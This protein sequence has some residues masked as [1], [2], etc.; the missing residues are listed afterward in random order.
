M[1]YFLYMYMCLKHL[2]YVP[3]PDT[4]VLQP[5]SQSHDP[6]V[7]TSVEEKERWANQKQECPVCV[8]P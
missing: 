1:K 5:Y 6:P 2:S 4:F 3:C 8:L 7:D